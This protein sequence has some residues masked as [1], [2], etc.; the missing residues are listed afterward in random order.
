MAQERTFAG[1]H[2]SKRNNPDEEK[3]SRATSDTFS[4]G[5]YLF[6]LHASALRRNKFF[7]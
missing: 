4:Q 6:L 5:Y 3:V 2:A 7:P 1:Y